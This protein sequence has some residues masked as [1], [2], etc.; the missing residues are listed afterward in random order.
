MIACKI[1]LV[2][3]NFTFQ[4]GNEL[5]AALGFLKFPTSHEDA[6]RRT[7]IPLLTTHHS[8]D[9]QINFLVAILSHLFL[10]FHQIK[11]FFLL[12]ISW[13]QG[14]CVLRPHLS[15]L[16]SAGSI[17]RNTILQLKL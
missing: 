3:D 13:H 16:A 12:L 14:C 10:F 7:R 4:N 6:D 1:R 15:L 11:M 17:Q 8:A 2:K 9:M 5:L